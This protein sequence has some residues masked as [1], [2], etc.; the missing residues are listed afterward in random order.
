MKI[1]GL[2]DWIKEDFFGPVENMVS[3]TSYHAFQSK[4]HIEFPADMGFHQ[5][6]LDQAQKI[7]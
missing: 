7:E 1:S 2:T 6:V 3:K 5:L 4:R